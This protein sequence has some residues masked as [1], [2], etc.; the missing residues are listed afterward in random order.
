[1]LLMY[2][3]FLIIHSL[4]SLMVYLPTIDP[5]ELSVVAVSAF[6]T[7]S[8]WSSVMS[9]SSY[10]YGF[11]QA[12]LYTP[13]MLVT[14]DPFLQYKLMVLVGGALLSLIPLF[15]YSISYKLGAKKPWQAG[16]CALICGGYV[17]HF[18]HSNFVW[19]ETIAIFL[20]WFIAW[21]F[22][23]MYYKN[24]GRTV[25][26]T[27]SLVLGAVLA[28]SLGA[29]YRLAAVVLSV[30]AALLFAKFVLK[31]KIVRLVPFFSSFVIFFVLQTLAAMGIQSALWKTLE[32]ELL[33][34]TPENFFANLPS[35]LS[36]G[37][38]VRFFQAVLAQLYYF[39]VSSWGLGALGMF[40]FFS[41]AK[42]FFV[43]RRKKIPCAYSSG[44]LIFSCFSFFTVLFTLFTGAFYK[45]SSDAFYTQQDTMLFGRYL[46]GVTPLA[47]LFALVFIFLHDLR[48][49][50]IFGGASALLL[51]AAAYYVFALPVTL[52]A[53]TTR[54]SP[55]L[56]LYPLLIGENNSTVLSLTSILAASSSALSVLALFVVIVSC[57]KKLKPVVISVFFLMTTVYSAF[58]AAFYYI[59]L[60]NSES[61]S[62]NAAYTEIS[63]HLFNQE[64]APDITVYRTTRNAAMMLQYL[65]QNTTVI[66]AKNS[67]EIEENSFVVVPAGEILR[68]HTYDKKIIFVELART[69]EYSVYAYGEKALAYAQSQ[70]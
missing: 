17:T 6:F 2:I 62:K 66:Y 5:N 67:R 41:V 13:I 11:V 64:E 32:P 29:H 34:N 58:F 51:S 44:F 7:G 59:P 23:R 36:D 55:I 68:F 8:D 45:F 24:G 60:C 21:L 26:M 56:A 42:D 37:G 27:S 30:I 12:A 40:L 46:D 19:N 15:A 28:L 48:L 14:R 47:I 10:Y 20:P 31:K 52:S 54:I 16:L 18:A 49:K 1:M 39:C 63:A 57:T 65:N 50:H 38:V 43:S 35:A 25:K 3:F 9:Q 4:F 33:N 53:Q 69:A 22:F 61:E 70:K